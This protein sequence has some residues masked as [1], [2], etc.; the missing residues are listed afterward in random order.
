MHFK[1]W[2]PWLVPALGALWLA[3]G[4]GFSAATLDKRE[5]R[6]PYLK[7][8]RLA[9]NSQQ[10]DE[11]IESYNQ[12]LNRKPNLALGHLEVGLLY[13]KYREDY[14]RAIYH[15]QRYIEL[16]PQAEKNHLVKDLID[17]ARLAYA[18]SL[19]D[20]PSAAIE[21]IA[22]LKQEIS[23][24]KADLARQ[25]AASGGGRAGAAVAGPAAALRPAPAQ[26]AVETYRVQPGDTLSSIAAK[27]YNDSRKWDKIYEANRNVLSS[28]QSLRQGQTLVIPALP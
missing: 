9:K 26:P 18:A 19:P 24:L 14:V 16:R 25:A 3:S 12:A 20:R 10:I 8:A 6:D 28:P 5:E 13:D 11:A 22:F 15:Y 23:R 21:E 2:R 7:R 4:C 1:I 27:V 17:K